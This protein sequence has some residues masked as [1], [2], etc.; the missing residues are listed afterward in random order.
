MGLPNYSIPTL[1]FQVDEKPDRFSLFRLANRAQLP[2]AWKEL[3]RSSLAS[4]SGAGGSLHPAD[5]LSPF[6]PVL[7]KFLLN[8]LGVHHDHTGLEAAAW[9][10]GNGSAFGLAVDKFHLLGK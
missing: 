2:C 5:A 8:G 9:K 4:A 3:T 1:A 10:V 7:P 6:L